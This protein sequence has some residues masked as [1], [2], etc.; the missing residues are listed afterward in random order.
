MMGD[1]GGWWIAMWVLMTLFWVAV[2]AG[3][4]W[5]VTSIRASSRGSAALEV[6]DQRLARGEID[7]D[8]HRRLKAE[9]GAPV[10]RSG[11]SVGWIVAGLIGVGLVAVMATGA[12]AGSWDMW[13]HMGGMH[14]G[15]RDASGS[16]VVKS[17][18]TASVTIEDFAFQPGNLQVPIGA[19]P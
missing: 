10:S 14:G 6:L 16:S 9:L 18:M 19:R 3:V 5:F 4:V 8:E 11:P 2:I 1:G 17:G 15:G 12:F 13:D 7:I